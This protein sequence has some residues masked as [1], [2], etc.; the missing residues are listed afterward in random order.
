MGT[1]ELLGPRLTAPILA[2]APPLV[3]RMESAGGVA[4]LFA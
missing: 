3:R 2:A 1:A 4:G